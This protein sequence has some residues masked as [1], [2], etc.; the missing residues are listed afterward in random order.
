MPNLYSPLFFTS[1]NILLDGVVDLIGFFILYQGDFEEGLDGG[2]KS[3]NYI[4]D[5]IIRHNDRHNLLRPETVES[6]FVL[7]RI[8]GDPK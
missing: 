7:H 8:T 6:L 4:N 1:N 2:N 3:S 5:I